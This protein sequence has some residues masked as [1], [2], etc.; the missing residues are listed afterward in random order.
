MNYPH[1]F[2]ARG[3]VAAAP[4]ALFER[5]D[6]PLRLA[7][8]MQR[9]SMAMM[10]STMRVDTDARHGRALGSLIRMR[11]RFLGLPLTL[12]EMVVERDPPRRKA[13]QTIGEPHLLAMGAYRMGFV[14]ETT[15]RGAQLTVFIDYQLPAS[16]PWRWLGRLLAP[17]YAR[18]CCNRM[19]Q[20]AQ[21][22]FAAE[23]E[24]TLAR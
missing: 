8:H 4:D 2:A 21:A 9:R 1:H 10:G 15:P 24:T 11:G 23:K 12:D 20:D 17:L 5:L 18:W 3:W 13:W 16:V 6:D 22:A 19:L 14:I 7:S